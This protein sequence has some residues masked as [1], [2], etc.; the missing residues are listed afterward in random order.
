MK[1]KIDYTLLERWRVA[2]NETWVTFGTRLVK[3]MNLSDKPKSW[4]ILYKA[5]MGLSK[6]NARNEQKI[7][8]YLVNNFQRIFDD[9]SASFMKKDD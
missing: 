3:E 9:I 8:I 1:N 5:A 4:M 6:P 2:L 7:Q